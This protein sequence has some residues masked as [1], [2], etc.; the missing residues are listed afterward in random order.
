MATGPVQI[1][2]VDLGPAEPTGE[3]LAE[4]QRLSE[5]DIVRL[6]DLLVV[7][8][9]PDGQMEALDIQATPDGGA[10]VAVLAGLHGEGNGGPPEAPG[11]SSEA[12]D[13]WYVED[14]IPHD[15]TVAVALIEHRWAAGL[16]AALRNRGGELL[17]EA[18][19]H[20]LD[21]VAAGLA[22]PEEE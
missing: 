22:E 8:R 12:E 1:L 18:W 6:L 11:E 17:A 3:V 20:P 10:K 9:H 15:T 7:R 21:L 2:V 16:S 13:V 19:I 14:S 5:A 4:L